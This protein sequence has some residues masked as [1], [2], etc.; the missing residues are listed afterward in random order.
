M[1][2]TGTASVVGCNQET[3][4]RREAKATAETALTMWKA[5]CLLNAKPRSPRSGRRS[6]VKA[7]LARGV[8]LEPHE[9]ASG[10]V[11]GTACY[12]ESIVYSDE[13]L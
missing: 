5:N 11:R 9:G 4:D 12:Q 7:I 8:V 3:E 1:P 10:L 13:F 6:I 2:S